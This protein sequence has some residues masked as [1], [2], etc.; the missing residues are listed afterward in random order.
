MDVRKTENWI[1]T[2]KKETEMYRRCSCLPDEDSE[3]NDA[4]NTDES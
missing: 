2:K 1:L 4:D 3:E